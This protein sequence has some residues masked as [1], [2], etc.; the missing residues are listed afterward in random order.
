MNR[1]LFSASIVAV[2]LAAAPAAFAT[3]VTTVDHFTVGK[4][5]K[6]TERVTTHTKTGVVDTHTTFTKAGGQTK[7]VSEKATPE[8]TG[9]YSVSKTVSGFNGRSSSTT[10]HAAT[11][12]GHAKG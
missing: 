6:V 1:F 10:S 12:T 5:T 4:H 3:P 2:A 8:A 7:T 9:G 11:A